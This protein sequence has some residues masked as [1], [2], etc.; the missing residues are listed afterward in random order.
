MEQ[1]LQILLYPQR[2]LFRHHWRHSLE[3]GLV[4]VGDLSQSCATERLRSYM[5]PAKLV[6]EAR[7]LIENTTRQRRASVESSFGLAVY[8]AP[9]YRVTIG[10]CLLGR[11]GFRLKVR[12]CNGQL[13]RLWHRMASWSSHPA[14]LFA[15]GSFS[16]CCGVCVETCGDRTNLSAYVETSALRIILDRSRLVER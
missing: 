9:L 10:A 1:V 7:S 11:L 6:R 12:W 4:H 8:T 2:E 16:T 3:S 13:P 14:A 15:R 5:R